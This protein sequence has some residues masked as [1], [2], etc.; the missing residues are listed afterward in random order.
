[1]K[2]T[3][4]LWIRSEHRIDFDRALRALQDEAPQDNIDIT[5]ALVEGPP[6]GEFHRYTNLS[7]DNPAFNLFMKNHGVTIYSE[8]DKEIILP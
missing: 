7:A 4:M 6:S 2:G 1:M 5:T 3:M 8:P